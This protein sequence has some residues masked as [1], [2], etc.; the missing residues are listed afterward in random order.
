MPTVID[1]LV[2][3]LGLDPSKFTRGQREAMSQLR[4]FQEDAAKTGDLIERKGKGTLDFFMGFRR[5]L[6]GTIGLLS[7]GFGLKNFFE[8]VTKADLRVE[9][10][11]RRIMMSGRE[12]AVW[13][14]AVEASGGSLEGANQALA[15][16]SERIATFQATGQ[17]DSG[18]ALLGRRAGWNIMDPNTN[19]MDVWLRAI[20]NMEAEGLTPVQKAAQM[21]LMGANEDLINFSLLGSK[22][23]ESQLARMREM[24]GPI[25]KGMELAREYNQAATEMGK[26]WDALAQ[27]IVVATGS[28]V[29]N[30]L[31]NLTELFQSV[32]AAADSP[33]VG[34]RNMTKA[35]FG[36]LFNDKDLDVMFGENSD[37]RRL[38]FQKYAEKLRKQIEGG[39]AT[40]GR[41]SPGYGDVTVAEVE[42]M[43]RAEAV[44]RGI[45][46]NIA[47]RVAQSEGL[48]DYRS[49]AVTRRGTREESYGPYQLSFEGKS[50]LGNE[51]V[52]RTGI[53]P[54][55]D[56]SR[57][58]ILAQVRFSLDEAARSGWGAWHGWKG[59]PRAGLNGAMPFVGSG[60]ASGGNT[61][62]MT[63]N[64]NEINVNGA[65]VTDAKTFS[66]EVTPFLKR[67]M[68]GSLS[69]RGGN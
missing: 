35:A 26:A 6:L 45:D 57:S 20:R 48:Y 55:I 68:M 42:Q 41:K 19:P 7:G 58:S 66:D 63:T 43:I 8:G 10:L 62:H 40:A 22:A 18:L 27:T 24:V 38:A 29:T 5:E 4:H 69:E 32:R 51:F 46:P 30:E 56:R 61:Y 11:S 65:R 39:S 21:R 15:S 53:D 1:S 25:E 36:W 47:L 60:N 67:G 52:R 49:A 17:M 3:E 13:S 31:R 64:V 9:Q 16:L 33:L 44:K 14:K 34:V 54:R 28:R 23:I 12:I 59:A 37:E 2:L 50:H